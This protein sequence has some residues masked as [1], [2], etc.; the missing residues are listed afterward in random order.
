MF[1]LNERDM[2]EI[3]TS[4]II[5]SFT[6]MVKSYILKKEIDMKEIIITTIF[7]IISK[8]LCI[9]VMQK[10]DSYIDK[11]KSKK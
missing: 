4:L 6:S 3:I 2:I 1:E 7:I 11:K 10:V 5:I 8:F 9:R